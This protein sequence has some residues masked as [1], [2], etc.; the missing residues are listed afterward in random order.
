MDTGVVEL[1]SAETC[2]SAPTSSAS[3]IETRL[4]AAS[5]SGALSF[6]PV[7]VR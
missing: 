6:A 2:Q 7:L 5:A 4:P 1:M 3:L